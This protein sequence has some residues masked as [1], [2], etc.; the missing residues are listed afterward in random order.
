MDVVVANAGGQADMV[1]SNDGSGNFT[2]MATL[3]KSN[4]L[5]LWKR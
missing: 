5:K 1:Y 3:M 4:S 2:P